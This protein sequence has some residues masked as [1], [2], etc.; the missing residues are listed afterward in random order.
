MLR[1]FITANFPFKYVIVLVLPLILAAS[2]YAL[3]ATNIVAASFAGDGAAPINPYNV[4]NIRYT[5]DPITPTEIRSVRLEVNPTGGASGPTTVYVRINN[6]DWVNCSGGPVT[7]N[8]SFQ[9]S[10]PTVSLSPPT[11][12][13]VVAAQ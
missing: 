2:A 9:A 10:Y 11:T 6:G 1:R 3:A 5:L 13:Q 4:A 7:W 12:L 8:C